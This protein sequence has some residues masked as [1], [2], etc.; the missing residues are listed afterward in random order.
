MGSL[1]KPKH[2]TKRSDGRKVQTEKV[3]QKQT[4]QKA[5]LTS[6]NWVLKNTQEIQITNDCKVDTKIKLNTTSTTPTQKLICDDAKTFKDTPCESEQQDDQ[7]SGQE[8]KQ[9][10]SFGV[11]G[12]SENAEK[13][14]ESKQK[15]KKSKVS[16]K[17]SERKYKAKERT[18]GE[19]EDTNL[20]LVSYEETELGDEKYYNEEELTKILS[21]SSI[22]KDKQTKIEDSKCNKSKPTFIFGSRAWRKQHT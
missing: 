21:W 2:D 10:L 14:R 4:L 16:C 20:S 19:E 13:L 17:S 3:S 5:D 18:R 6:K 22:N 15:F 11:F 1:A 8:R 7:M 12:G 9:F